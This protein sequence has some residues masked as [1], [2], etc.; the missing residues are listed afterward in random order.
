MLK[1]VLGNKKL[2]AIFFFARH[3]HYSI[4]VCSIP[5]DGITGSRPEIVLWSVPMGLLRVHQSEP[6]GLRLF[7]FRNLLPRVPPQQSRI[8]GRLEGPSTVSW[9]AFSTCTILDD[10]SIFIYTLPI[11]RYFQRL[12]A[13]TA[14]STK[15]AA[16]SAMKLAPVPLPSRSE[17]QQ[18]CASKD[19][20]VPTI[21]PSIRINA[22][23]V[24]NVRVRCARRLTN[25]ESKCQM[26]ATLGQFCKRF[27]PSLSPTKETHD[28]SVNEWLLAGDVTKPPSFVSLTVFQ[29]LRCWPVAVHRRPLRLPL[30]SARRSPLH[31]VR[32]PP[33]RLHGQMLLLPNERWQLQH[34]SWKRT[35]LRC[36]ISGKPLFAAAAF[37]L[38]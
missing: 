31:D 9:V 25:R 24:R 22:S 30:R 1:Y 6:R 32:W 12:T 21:Q 2:L 16:R 11:I 7:R 3:L 34:R 8:T 29:H 15:C 38:Y 13:T 14:V 5:M 20:T 28:F 33:L 27:I 10:N 18:I 17:Q 35:L 37:V 19:A 4:I 26:I 36:H 23:G